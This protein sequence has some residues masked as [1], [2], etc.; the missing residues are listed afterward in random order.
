MMEGLHSY[1]LFIIYLWHVAY[2]PISNVRF[3]TGGHDSKTLVLLVA[4][5]TTVTLLLGGMTGSSGS[6]MEVELPT[7]TICAPNEVEM[8][9]FGSAMFMV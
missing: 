5:T 7:S 9:L 2:L 1:Q 6:V 8:N 3:V 4:T